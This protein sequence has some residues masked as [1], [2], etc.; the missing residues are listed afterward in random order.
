M[1]AGTAGAESRALKKVYTPEAK[2]Q[3]KELAIELGFKN[4]D[5]TVTPNYGAAMKEFWKNPTVREDARAAFA[6]EGILNEPE[7]PAETTPVEVKGR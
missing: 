5:G 2:A 4:A 6:D 7:A 1:P 3:L